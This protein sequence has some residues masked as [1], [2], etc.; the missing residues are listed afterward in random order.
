MTVKTG[1][2]VNDAAYAIKFWSF[3][4]SEMLWQ[5][6]Y[7]FHYTQSEFQTVDYCT[8]ITT[9]LIH[10]CTAIN[11]ASITRVLTLSVEAHKLGAMPFRLGC[12]D[13]I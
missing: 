11:A 3:I 8:H 12:H 4:I 9:V 13:S 5:P 6:P 1:K 10:V 7:E 2:S